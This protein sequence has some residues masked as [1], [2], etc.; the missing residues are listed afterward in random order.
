MNHCNAGFF[1]QVQFALN[2]IQYAERHGL[3]P[4]V[5]FGSDSVDGPN[6]FYE[7]AAGP[8]VWEY[9]FEPIGGVAPAE[10]R[11]AASQG[12]GRIWALDYWELWRLH[13]HDP[14][15]VFTYPYGYYERVRDRASRPDERWWRDQRAKGRDL[16]ARHVRVRPEILA[17]VDAFQTARFTPHMLGVHA[18]GTDKGDTG[19]GAALARVV[20]PEE[21]FPLIDRHLADHP[22][23]RIFFATD[24][25][26]FVERMRERYG[27]RLVTYD[28]Q[29]SDSTVNVFQQL[30]PAGRGNRAKGED[31]LIDALL[32]SRCDALLKCTS[33]VGEFAQYFADDLPA[34]D[35][36]VAGVPTPPR[37][38]IR[39][40]TRNV[41]WWVHAVATRLWFE[42]LGRGIVDAESSIRPHRLYDT[43]QFEQQSSPST[44]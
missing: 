23:D 30:A 11:R 34:V 37:R 19:T 35:L 18:R 8:N 31:V 25:R 29:R 9:Y 24:Q 12:E 6:A 5:E 43:N 36:N 39:G 20:P 40:V 10:A 27:D 21:Y 22:D 26:Q 14:R 15:S 13:W 16:V 38:T 32:L 1:A 4:V 7:E 3:V 41:K 42:Q 44:S 28:S 17:K 33:A 2:Q